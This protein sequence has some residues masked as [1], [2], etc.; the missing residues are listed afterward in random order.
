MKRLGNLWKRLVGFEN[1]LLA[2]RK[3]RRGKRRKPGVALFDLNLEKELLR[4]QR[5][6]LSGDYVPGEYRLFTIYERKPRVIAAAPFR[7]RVVH[8]ALMNVIEAP[9]DRRFIFDCYACRAGKG[10]HAAVARYQIWARS[11]AYALKMDISRYFPSVDHDLLKAKLRRLIKDRH[12]LAVLD[13][14][15]D[16]GPQRAPDAPLVYFPGD[17][18]FTPLERRIG[19]PI[20]NLTSQFFA[21]LYLNDFDHW[22]QENL[23]ASAYLRYVD[24][25]VILDDDKGRLAE[26][27]AMVRD[28]LRR[29]RLRLHPN[30]AHIV[31]VSGGLDLLGYRV[32][33]KHRFLRND[34]GWRFTRKLRRFAKAY[35][36]GTLNWDDFN[37][38][39]QSWI[40]HASHA[41]TLGLREAIFS[42]IIFTRGA[43]HSA[44][45]G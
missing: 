37:P 16:S 36:K 18:L 17:D 14:I 44:A 7:D 19:L 26:I 29:E 30:K 5:D 4:L 39:V 28:A 21:N 8:H 45:V 32:F 34:N 6:L 38:A 40:G 25:M 15:V 31:P 35:S 27:K 13:K 2:F 42:R 3:A 24:D 22:V 23:H 11:H 12:V 41:D 10:A 9:L 20:G 43:G 33:P 1:L